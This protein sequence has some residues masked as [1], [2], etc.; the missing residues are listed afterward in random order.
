MKKRTDRSSTALRLENFK[1][2]VE[3]RRKMEKRRQF[4]RKDRKLLHIDILYLGSIIL[5]SLAAFSLAFKLSANG[6]DGLAFLIIIYYIAAFLTFVKVGNEP[7]YKKPAL[8]IW[9]LVIFVT[10]GII[11]GLQIRENKNFERFNRERSEYVSYME[12]PINSF[13]Q[14]QNFATAIEIEKNFATETVPGENGGKATTYYQDY[15]DVYVHVSKDFAELTDKEILEYGRNIFYK[16]DEEFRKAYNNADYYYFCIHNSRVPK[17][18]GYT[19]RNDDIK[20]NFLCDADIYSFDKYTCD[21]EFS[22]NQEKIHPLKKEEKTYSDESDT[23]SK[24][25][26]SSGKPNNSSTSSS[27]FFDPDDY[28]SPDDFADDAWGY[29]FDSWDDAYDFWEDW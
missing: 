1:K 5:S 20:L 29:S 13:I 19:R 7:K 12:E 6:K 15:L 11:I 4:V 24:G 18:T 16:I 3:L 23:T 9:G 26:D 14:S 28:D 22:R 17:A 27:Y 2:D 10:V 8:I 25:Y 21:F